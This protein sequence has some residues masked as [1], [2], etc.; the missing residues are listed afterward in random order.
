[1]HTLTLIILTTVTLFASISWATGPLATLRS[2]R[3]RILLTNERLAELKRLHKSDTVLQKYVTKVLDEANRACDDDL[4]QL[5]TDARGVLLVSAHHALDRTLLLGFAWQWSGRQTYHDALLTHTISLAKT[6]NWMGSIHFLD[7]A[8]MCKAVGIAYD[9]LYD[10]LDD[11]DRN[12]I[13]RA[14]YEKGV[15]AGLDAHENKIWWSQSEFNWN[16]VCNSGLTIAALA[17]ADEYPDQCD[18]LLEYTTASLPRALASYAPDGAWPEGTAYWHFAT[19]RVAFALS[20]MHTT[21]DTMFNLETS[22]GLSETGWFPI[23]TLSPRNRSLGYADAKSDAARKTNPTLFWLAQTYGTPEWANYEHAWL[24]DNPDQ[25]TPLHIVWYTPPADS[26]WSQPMDRHI[27]GLVPVATFRS[28]WNDEHAL[29][30][31]IKAGQA[32]V[33]H[34][35]MDMGTFEFDALGKRWALDL[36]ADYYALPG[37]WKWDDGKRFQYYRLGSHSHNVPALGGLQQD[38]K[39]TSEITRFA[40]NIDEPFVIIDLSGAYAEF[41]TVLR[42]AKLLNNRRAILIQDEYTLKNRT[43]V[44]WGMTTP[45]RVELKGMTPDPDFPEHQARMIIDDE[46][47]LAHLL[48]PADAAFTLE[49]T[50]QA[51][52]QSTNVGTQRL[53]VHL[54]HVKEKVTIAILFEPLW[55]DSMLSQH[56]DDNLP[57]I[58]HLQE[59]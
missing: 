2:D 5:H 39:G 32:A 28:D 53:V 10:S 22:K 33:H 26:V 6:P 25:I 45:A 24:A 51:P 43:D 8:T 14:I 37:Y 46:V 12:L 54:P 13:A 35:H 18:R 52:P 9:W 3:P 44:K 17:V 7:T 31:G 56:G 40:G 38:W 36:G 21:L 4:V 42:G 1:M 47:V 58:V 48:S 57:R 41:G 19:S 16:L 59:W 30:F 27:K 15:Q 50:W 23:Y 34:G 11:Q 55:P 20:A 29:F 49:S